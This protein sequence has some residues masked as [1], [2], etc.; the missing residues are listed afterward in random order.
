MLQ[1]MVGAWQDYTVAWTSG[2]TAPSI[3]NGTLTGR[4]VILGDTGHFSIKLTGGST[5]NWGTGNYLW[6]LP[7]TAAAAADHVGT[8][9]VGDSSAGSGAYSTGIAFLSTGGTTV[10]GYVGP[11]NGASSLSNLNPQTFATGDRI[12]LTGTYEL[13]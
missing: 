9:F 1:E 10:G 11:K 3:G 8:V 5:T 7:V 13:A 4:Y 12:W 6:S 2:G